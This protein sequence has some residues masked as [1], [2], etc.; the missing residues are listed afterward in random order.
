MHLNMHSSTLSLALSYIKISLLAVEL[1]GS[2]SHASAWLGRWWSASIMSGWFF[3]TH[4]SWPLVAFGQPSTNHMCCETHC[5][6]SRIA[7]YWNI[8]QKRGCRV[9]YFSS[10][11]IWSYCF[12]D[13]ISFEVFLLLFSSFSFLILPSFRILMYYKL[14]SAETHQ[15]LPFSGHWLLHSIWNYLNLLILPLGMPDYSTSCQHQISCSLR[16]NLEMSSEQYS[17]ET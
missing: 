15:M 12:I 7:E 3:S 1:E 13:E 11:C 10:F 9:V 6:N 4:D 8:V 5:A 2:G 14:A 16:A 17:S